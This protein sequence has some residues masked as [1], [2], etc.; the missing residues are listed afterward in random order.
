MGCTAYLVARC[1][2]E[3]MVILVCLCEVG[4]TSR[5]EKRRQCGFVSSTLFTIL[6][7]KYKMW[8][9]VLQVMKPVTQKRMQ[10]AKNKDMELAHKSTCREKVMLSLCSGTKPWRY[11][12]MSSQLKTPAT[13]TLQKQH[14]ASIKHK[15]QWNLGP[16]WTWQWRE[17][18]TT[19]STTT[20]PVHTVTGKFT[21][22]Q[23]LYIPKFDLIRSS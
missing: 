19:G 12:Q 22:W 16:V 18:T 17:N 9:T 1:I 13:L 14:H 21:D 2:W 6:K 20:V 4:D 3:N 5:S 23:Q 10:Y 15:T 8:P 7:N 11:T